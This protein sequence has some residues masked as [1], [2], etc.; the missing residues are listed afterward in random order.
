MHLRKLRAYT[1]MFQVHKIQSQVF[2]SVVHV[3]E[4]VL[5]LVRVLPVQVRL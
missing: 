1:L 2:V 3:L 5:V 4:Q